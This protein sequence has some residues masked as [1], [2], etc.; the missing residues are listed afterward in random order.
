MDSAPLRYTPFLRPGATLFTIVCYQYLAFGRTSVTRPIAAVYGRVGGRKRNLF[1]IGA[2]KVSVNVFGSSLSAIEI[3]QDHTLFGV[4]SRALDP[5]GASLWAKMILEEGKF[6]RRSFEGMLPGKVMGQRAMGPGRLEL[7]TSELRSCASCVADD[8]AKFGF[9]AWDVLHLLPP[10]HHCP[11]H[12]LPLVCEAEARPGRNLWKLGLPQGKGP[13]GTSTKGPPPSDGYARYLQLWI[14]LFEGRLPTAAFS[15][16]PGYIEAAVEALGSAHEAKRALCAA[17]HRIWGL[18][19]AGVSATL[20][21]H[22]EKNFVD[23]EISHTTTPTR[24]AQKLVLITALESLGLTPDSGTCPV[25]MSLGLTAI[26]SSRQLLRQTVLATG[27]SSALADLLMSDAQR[28]RIKSEL[29]L[30]YPRIQRIIGGFPTELL[31]ALRA[32]GQWSKQ[33]WLATELG[34]RKMLKKAPLA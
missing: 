17:V 34:R 15:A 11:K 7:G 4:Y 30:C 31:R 22:V 3:L 8:T 2:A 5:Y 33:S 32:E 9:A 27:Y 23:R 13:S 16:W 18:D 26:T 14:E 10:V 28:S 29:G 12:G 1:G 19:A 20:G 6:E 21:G 25:Q 24:I